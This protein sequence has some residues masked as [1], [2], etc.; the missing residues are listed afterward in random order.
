MPEPPVKKEKKED[1]QQSI[2]DAM[3]IKTHWLTGNINVSLFWEDMLNLLFRINQLYSILFITYY[4]YWP[5]RYR[6]EMT[7]WYSFWSLSFYMMD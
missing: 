6:E 5:S 2:T 4:E 7:W 3:K 1:E